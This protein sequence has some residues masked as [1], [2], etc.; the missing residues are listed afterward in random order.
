M[1]IFTGSECALNRACKKI[2]DFTETANTVTVRL[3]TETHLKTY[4]ELLDNRI[5]PFLQ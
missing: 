2:N 5:Q 3:R 1:H 4:R